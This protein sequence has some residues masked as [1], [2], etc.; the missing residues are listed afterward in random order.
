MV[1]EMTR[2]RPARPTILVVEDDDATRDVAPIGALEA[3]CR[4]VGARDGTEA[5]RILASG[6]AHVVLLDLLLPDIDGREILRRLGGS[7][8]RCCRSS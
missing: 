8:S 4:P 5:L 2:G 6:G 7:S 3:E 1:D